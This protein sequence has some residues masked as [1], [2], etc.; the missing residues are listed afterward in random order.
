LGLSTTDSLNRINGLRSI[1]AL[2]VNSVAVV[3]FVVHAH[4]AWS[5]VG[6]MAGS[7]IVAGYVGARVARRIPSGVLRTVI[8][9]LGLATAVHLLLD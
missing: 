7:S 5:A 8:L 1:L 9:V 4:V 6:L 2:T 3:I